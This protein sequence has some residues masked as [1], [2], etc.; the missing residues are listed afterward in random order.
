[1]K[2]RDAFLK[3]LVEKMIKDFN[4]D[5]VFVESG[6]NRIVFPLMSRK[7]PVI[8]FSTSLS[9]DYEKNSPPFFS[10][11]IPTFSFFNRLY[12]DLIWYKWYIDKWFFYF[13]TELWSLGHF[14]YRMSRIC[15]AYGLSKNILDTKRVWHMGFK[16]IPEI[17]FYPAQFDFTPNTKKN[18]FYIGPWVDIER[19]EAKFNTGFDWGKIEVN[20]FLLCCCMGSQARFYDSNIDAFYKKII[21]AVGQRD[22][23]TLIMAVGDN[24]T[25]DIEKLPANVH[26]FNSIPQIEIL[27][28][29]NLMIHHGGMGSVRECV[30]LEVP[31]L[32]YPLDP[33]ID[34]HGSAARIEYFKLG[35]RGNHRRDCSST[36]LDKID[37]IL[38]NPFIKQ[39]IC[40]WSHIF[41]DVENNTKILPIMQ[42]ARHAD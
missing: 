17:Y 40:E 38:H 35:L 11:I 33:L 18:K 42:H 15:Q 24:S 29:A 30:V 16:D 27:K 31:M 37:H 1:L 10:D 41:K 36:I 14:D 22:K 6:L 26:V 39:N 32:V 25:I 23:Y 21:E 19:N 4:P 13:K 5:T 28:K 7:L 20:E 3:L 34:Q 12:I 9:C 8:M 2:Q